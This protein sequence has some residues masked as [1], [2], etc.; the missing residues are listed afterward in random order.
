MT[1]LSLPTHGALELLTGV[2]LIASPLV[3][4]F[5]PAG[6]IGATVA[7]VLIA[8]LGLNDRLPVAVHHAA[9]SVLAGAL[10]AAAVALAAAGEDL[11]AGVLAAAAAVELALDSVTRWTRRV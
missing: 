9:D 4:E 5:G 10:L 11:A 7:G 3:F 1:R 2:A 8:G 6:L